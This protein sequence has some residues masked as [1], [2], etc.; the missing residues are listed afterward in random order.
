MP[1]LDTV[2]LQLKVLPF[3]NLNVFKVLNTFIVRSVNRGSYL[4]Y[5]TRAILT[6]C[7]TT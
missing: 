7:Q 6:K 3:Q 2:Y 5:H 1:T 4:Q